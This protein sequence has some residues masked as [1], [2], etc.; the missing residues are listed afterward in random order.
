[1][2]TGAQ[3]TPGSRRADAFPLQHM[4]FPVSS[5]SLTLPTFLL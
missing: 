2:A 4:A 1:M 5:P 3:M